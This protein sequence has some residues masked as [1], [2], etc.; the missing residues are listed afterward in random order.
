MKRTL[1]VD[2]DGTIFEYD[3]YEFGKFGKPRQEVIDLLVEYKNLDPKKHQ[4]AIQTT[5]SWA[6]YEQLKERLDLF[7]VPYDIINMGSKCIGFAYLDD[8]AVNVSGK[9]EHWESRFANLLYGDEDA[10]DGNDEE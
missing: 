7:K 8:R 1:V 4:I 10:K 2:V 3:K 9:R 6:E 5:R